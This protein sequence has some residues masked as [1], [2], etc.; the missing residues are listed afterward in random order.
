VATARHAAAQETLPT[1]AADHGDGISARGRTSC[2][3]QPAR[4]TLLAKG[5]RLS[6][7]AAIAASRPGFPHKSLKLHDLNF[8]REI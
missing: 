1:L 7:G 3:V 4:R 2:R 6:I 8:M 5:S